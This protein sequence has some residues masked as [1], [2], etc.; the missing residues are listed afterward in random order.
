MRARLLPRRHAVQF[1]NPICQATTNRKSVKKRLS[2]RI[3]Q[4]LTSFGV[5]L[6]I[7]G[8]SAGFGAEFPTPLPMEPMGI[9]NSLPNPL[10]E[11]WVFVHSLASETIDLVDT[12]SPSP[13]NYRGMLGASYVA[14]FLQSSARPE[15]LVAETFFARGSRGE[16]TDVLTIYDRHTLAPSEEILLHGNKRGLIIPQPNA[17]QLSNDERFGLLFNFTPAS[18]VTVIDLVERRVINEVPIPGCALIYPTGLRG[19]SSLCANNTMLGVQLDENGNVSGQ[20]ESVAFNNLD[21]DPLFSAPAIVDGISHFVSYQ[22]NVQPIDL[23]SETPNLLT[24]WSLLSEEEAKANW[25][26]SGHQLVAGGVDRRLYV[27]MQANGKEGSHRDGGDQVWVFDTKNGTKVS[28]IKLEGTSQS[29]AVGGPDDSALFVTGHNG[30]LDRHDLST[31][32]LISSSSINSQG[33]TTVIRP[34]KNRQ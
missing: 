17:F 16:R 5:A 34:V 14:N 29:I 26:P 31:G 8:P 32:A 2:M 9:I 12:S 10:P 27:I 15:L 20:T 25:R 30:T 6:L 1:E 7:A 24:P 21:D 18:S 11:D 19:F 23:T 4:T 3:N 33:W 13:T 28:T 22:G